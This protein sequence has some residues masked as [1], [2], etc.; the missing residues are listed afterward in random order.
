MAKIKKK[1][2]KKF[3][4]LK[5]IKQQTKQHIIGKCLIC[6]ENMDQNSLICTLVKRHNYD[7]YNILRDQSLNKLN[8]KFYL[9][10]NLQ[11]K[12][13]IININNNNNITKQK[14]NLNI[15]T[16]TNNNSI[17]DKN[18]N[19]IL[20]DHTTYLYSTCGHEYHLECIKKTKIQNQESFDNLGF[21]CT[22][23]GKLS[24]TYFISNKINLWENPH[25]NL[26]FFI[27]EITHNNF[28]KPTISTNTITNCILQC[29]KL[30]NVWDNDLFKTRILPCSKQ[31]INMIYS[32]NKLQYSQINQISTIYTDILEKQENLYIMDHT[33]GNI[34]YILTINVEVEF[35]KI[36]IYK[37][38][39]KIINNKCQKYNQLIQIFENTFYDL[40]P[41]FVIIKYVQSVY[42]QNNIIIKNLPEYTKLKIIIDTFK[43]I[44]NLLESIL[45]NEEPTLSIESNNN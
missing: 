38:F 21:T 3:A 19:I 20:N 25:S 7:I 16:I 11:Q 8:N 35:T 1:G 5:P 30:R 36:F 44:L 40:L 17:L 9:N 28:L 32:I 26:D 39:L 10:N 41:I 2:K 15:E 43:Q 37:Y 29:I 42:I 14:C 18:D 33:K 23:C 27:D 13:S 4:K 34:Q 12:N 6:H 22:F 31:F 24:D 45:L